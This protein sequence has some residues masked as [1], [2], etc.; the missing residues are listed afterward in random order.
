M[1]KKKF[2]QV[3]FDCEN[4]LIDASAKIWNKIKTSLENQLKSGRK[5]KH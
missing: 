1:R 3:L 2:L 4:F 5:E